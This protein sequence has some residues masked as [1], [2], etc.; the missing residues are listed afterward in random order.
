MESRNLQIGVMAG[1]ERRQDDAQKI[2]AAVEETGY[3]IAQSGAITM[4]GAETKSDSI[5]HAACRGAKKGEGFSIAIQPGQ[6]I[7]NM[8]E[9]PDVIIASGVPHGGGREAILVS[10]C[11]GIVCINGGSGTLTEIAIAYQSNRPIVALKGYGGWSERLAGTYL[12]MRQRI[13]IEEAVT[14]KEAVEKVIILIR[15]KLRGNNI[16]WRRLFQRSSPYR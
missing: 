16:W 2:I 8:P 15:E 10:S 3:W 12:D 5:A 9:N 13:F 14:P 1:L 4:F 7:V 6:N 11:D